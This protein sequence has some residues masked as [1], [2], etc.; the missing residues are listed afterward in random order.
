MTSP[1]SLAT[2]NVNGRSIHYASAGNSA[3]PML[4]FLHGFPEA[5]FAWDEQL[6]AFGGDYFAVAPDLPGYNLS[7]KYA[8]V[9]DYRAHVVVSDLLAFAAAL[10]HEE[11]FLVGHDWGG[12]LAYAL[13]IAHPAQVRKLFIING[14]HPWIFWR[15]LSQSAEQAAHSQYINTFR[16]ERDFAKTIADDNYRF[17][18]RFFE[19]Q[20]RLPAWFD[21]ATQARYVQAWSQPGAVDGGLNYYRASPLYPPFDDDEGAGKLKLKAR[22]LIVKV[23]TMVLWGELDEF[24]LPGCLEGLRQVVPDLRLKR[25]PE[26]SH[27]LAHEL[28]NEV[29]LRLREHLALPA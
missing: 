11:F 1:I 26:A 8:E 21:A 25:Y 28:P 12:A 13:A 9:R 5:W 10:G 23:P 6:K 3:R 14:V 17:L 15:E 29:T 19:T 7:S 18:I 16:L 24:L 4:L 22:D 20:H 27:W 2:L